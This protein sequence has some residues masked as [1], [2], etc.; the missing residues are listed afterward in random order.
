MQQL[1]SSAQCSVPA[2]QYHHCYQSVDQ[3]LSFLKKHSPNEKVF[4]SSDYE[5]HREIL[6]KNFEI[7][8][9]EDIIDD[10]SKQNRPFIELYIH[11]I[12]NLFIANCPSSFSAF[13]VRQRTQNNLKTLFWGVENNSHTELQPNFQFFLMFR[14]GKMEDFLASQNFKS[15][16]LCSALLLGKMMVLS[17]MTSRQRIKHG[18]F[19]NKEDAVAAGLKAS[20]QYDLKVSYHNAF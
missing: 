9:L 4:I 20:N 17:I 3:I 11:S 19:S 14:K 18:K 6:S 8:T 10:F 15:Y 16:A 7:F 5:N 2:I 12:S 13:S 1:F